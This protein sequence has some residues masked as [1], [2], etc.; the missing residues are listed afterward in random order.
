MLGPWNSTLGTHLLNSVWFNIFISKPFNLDLSYLFELFY[1]WWCVFPV[2][3]AQVFFPQEN[4]WTIKHITELEMTCKSN[5]M[6]FLFFWVIHPIIFMLTPLC[7]GLRY[8]WQSKPGNVVFP[9][10]HGSWRYVKTCAFHTTHQLV[11]GSW[12]KWNGFNIT[13]PFQYTSLLFPVFQMMLN[14]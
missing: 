2:F 14:L 6:I 4:G 12:M 10:A 9:A 11:L 5:E 7:H 8:Y 13:R 3:Q 1:V